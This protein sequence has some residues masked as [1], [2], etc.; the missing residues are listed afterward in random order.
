MRPNFV[1]FDGAESCCLNVEI[2]RHF[3]QDEWVSSTSNFVE[4]DGTENFCYT[5]EI[6]RHFLR[7]EWVDQ[8]GFRRQIRTLI[9]SNEVSSIYQFL[10]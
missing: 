6:S 3:L 8:R 1:E 2:S 7:D 9:S 10:Q 5:V 4:F